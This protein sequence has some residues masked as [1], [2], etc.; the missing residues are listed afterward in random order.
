M[1]SCLHAQA[2]LRSSNPNVEPLWYL[3][4]L[5]KWL[6]S[7]AFYWSSHSRDSLLTLLCTS[8][9]DCWSMTGMGDFRKCL[10]NQSAATVEKWACLCAKDTERLH[11]WCVNWK[12]E[13]GKKISCSPVSFIYLFLSLLLS[14]SCH[15]SGLCQNVTLLQSGTH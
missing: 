7:C 2:R 1:H 5:K 9:M 10:H 8:V 4:A 14:F 12:E 15:L 6:Y 11:I 13:R 3:Q